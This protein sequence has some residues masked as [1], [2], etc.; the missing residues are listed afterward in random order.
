MVSANGVT[1]QTR[2]AEHG[3]RTIGPSGSDVDLVSINRKNNIADSSLRTFPKIQ[4]Y[5]Q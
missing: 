5:R 3:M 2:H 4:K 1:A